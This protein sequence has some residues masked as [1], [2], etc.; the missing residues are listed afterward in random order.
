[1]N[2]IR[3]LLSFALFSAFAVSVHALPVRV[4]DA[5][6]KPLPTVMVSVAPVTP[7]TI[8]ASDNGYAEPGKLQRALFETHR[9]TNTAGTTDLPTGSEPW[10]LRLRKPGFKDV[11]V[12]GKDYAGKPLVMAAET[13]PME[14]AAQKPSNVW[15]ST[16][17]FGDENLKKEWLLQCNFCHQQGSVFLRRNRTAEEWSTVIQRMVRYGARLSTE[18]QKKIPGLISAHW[19]KINANPALLPAAT[20]WPSDLD[21]FTVREM[22]I[23]DS[24]SQMHDLLHHSN[25][26]IYVG[27]NL[28]DRVY[29]IN[30][31]SGAY[32]V[33]K[34]PPFGSPHGGLLAGRLVDFP[35]HETYQGIHSLAESP[36]DGHIFITPSYQRRLLEFDPKTK[37]FSH[38]AMDQGFYPHTIRFDAKDRAWFTL[39]LSNQ[40]AHFDR[41]TRKFTYYDLPYRSVGERI[42]TFLMPTLFKLMSWGL[43][44]ANWAPVDHQSTGVT[45]P[46][47]IDTAPDGTIW[48]A[49]LHTDEIGSIDGETGKLTMIKTGFKAPPRLRGDR[50]ANVW[51]AAFNES[52]VVR[53]EPKTGTFTRFDLPVLPKGSDTPYSLNVDKPRHQVWV[54]GT[55]SDSIYRFDIASQKWDWIPLSRKGTFTRDVEFSPEGKVYITGAAFPSWH[56]EDAQPT[57]MEISVAG[58]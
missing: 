3:S 28:Q 15:T 34:V 25:G 24:F 48:F 40:I 55:N 14:L 29:E 26:L 11:L 9:F 52:L 5:Q 30:P 44:V 47:G 13:D 51:I 27:D 23:G 8:D 46:Y 54:N 49:R 58:K 45:L 31:R 20:P 43:P 37:Q 4:V 50:Y 35:K 19:E 18:G 33:Y 10:K 32:T 6:G 38:P 12:E 56:I 7:A 21:R 53:Y 16:V 36:K 2:A 39:A 17:D 1:M 42:T 57:L 22:P 41:S